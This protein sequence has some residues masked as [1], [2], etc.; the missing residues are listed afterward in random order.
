MSTIGTSAVPSG[1]A[2]MLSAPAAERNKQPIA[3]VLA[4]HPPFSS[5][6]AA[7]C[8]EVASGTGQHVAHLAK[9]FP[10]VTFQPTEYAWP[11]RTQR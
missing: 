6:T 7:T 11:D 3:D 2:N 4:R 8:L 1:L 9:A 5:T 10:H